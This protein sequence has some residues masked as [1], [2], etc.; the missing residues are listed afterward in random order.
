MKTFDFAQ[1]SNEWWSTRRGVPTASDFNRI[2]T[3]AQWKFA[4]GA[5]SYAVQLVA[6][7]LDPYYGL[8]DESSTKEMRAGTL[9]E[10]EHRQWYEMFREVD[11]KQIGFCLTDD[12]RF[13]CSPD[14]LV[15]TSG[16]VEIKRP[17]PAT[18]IKY[19]ID[20]GVPADYLPQVHGS[21]IVTGRQWWDFL[22]LC[23]GLPPL[24][25]RVEPNEKTEELRGHLE[26]FWEVYQD[27]KEQI[28]AKQAA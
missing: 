22:S 21:L 6:D 28:A 11:V 15:G 24:L 3:P 20:G 2:V 5:K 25:V 19:L 13:G 14:G 26:R 16:G 17:Q 18:Q 23:P 4:E 27:I 1:Y 8:R 9:A 7:T 10:P 12:G